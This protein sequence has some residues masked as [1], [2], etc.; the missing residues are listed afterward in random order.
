MQQQHQVFSFFIPA[1]GRALH[2]GDTAQRTKLGVDCPSYIEGFPLKFIPHI[3]AIHITQEAG[4]LQV[5]EQSAAHAAGRMDLPLL[6]RQLHD[7][8]DDV[9]SAGG[10]RAAA[11]RHSAAHQAVAWTCPSY[12]AGFPLLNVFP[13]PCHSHH[14]GGGR[15]AGWG[16]SPAH[17]VGGGPAAPSA[18]AAAGEH[19]TGQAGGWPAVHRRPH[20]P[21]PGASWIQSFRRLA[22]NAPSVGFSGRSAA[23]NA[24][25]GGRLHIDGHIARIRVRY[26]IGE[27]SCVKGLLFRTFGPPAAC[28]APTPTVPASGCVSILCHSRSNAITDWAGLAADDCEQVGATLI[29]KHCK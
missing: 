14:A 2:A 24:T 22:P 12:N 3:S 17:Q 19:H 26:L 9:I 15:A 28:C 5:G 29:A 1:G 27:Q 25:M 16:H 8:P 20:R 10:G 7:V 21:H 13:L 4:A 6:H 11:G 23:I 18:A